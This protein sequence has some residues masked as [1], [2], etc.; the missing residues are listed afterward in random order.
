M[1]DETARA[2]G[3]KGLTD[4]KFFNF[5]GTPKFVYVSCGLENHE[6]AQISFLDMNWCFT[7][8]RRSDYKPLSMIPPKPSQFDVMKNIAGRLSKD[9]P[10]VRVDLYEVEGKVYFSEMTFYPCS[11][12]LPFEPEKYDRA[13]GDEIII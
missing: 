4:Y 12:F 1:E 13:L 3:S 8:F 11:G 7:D 2:T 5:N 6:T 9:I 10:F